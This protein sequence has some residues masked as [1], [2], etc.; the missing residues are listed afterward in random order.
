MQPVTIFMA[1]D[2]SWGVKIAHAKFGQDLQIN[3][4]SDKKQ[5]D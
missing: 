3:F 5:T 2:H 4:A 1:H